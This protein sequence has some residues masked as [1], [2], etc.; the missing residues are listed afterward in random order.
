MVYMHMPIGFHPWKIE[1]IIL[2]VDSIIKNKY[3]S[4]YGQIWFLMCNSHYYKNM[5]FLPP[6]GWLWWLMWQI[7]TRLTFCSKSVTTPQSSLIGVLQHSILEYDS[8]KPT[9]L[10]RILLWAS[11]N[12]GL[13]QDPIKQCGLMGIIFNSLTWTYAMCPFQHH[14]LLNINWFNW[15]IEYGC[16]DIHMYH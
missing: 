4:Q 8:H 15:N 10:D 12:L 9:L 5:S 3:T 14:F 11:L 7:C 1:S 2:L 16:S 13:K 6:M